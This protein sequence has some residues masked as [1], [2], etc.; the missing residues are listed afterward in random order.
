MTEE[1]GREGR[2]GE[3]NEN[4]KNVE[5]LERNAAKL[6]FLARVSPIRRETTA[7]KS[8]T[9][10]YNDESRGTARCRFIYTYAIR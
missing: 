8:E 6:A 2:R 1:E 5:V 7:K 4:E 10:Y 9:N 3:E